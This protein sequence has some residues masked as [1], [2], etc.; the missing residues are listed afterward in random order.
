MWDPE[1]SHSGDGSAAVGC[2]SEVET[3]GAL[4]P[5]V[6]PGGGRGRNRS[7]GSCFE[8]NR[9]G[10]GMAK[11]AW[12][13][14]KPRARELGHRHG[15]KGGLSSGEPRPPQPRPDSREEE[16]VGRRTWNPSF[17][18]CPAQVCPLPPS[19]PGG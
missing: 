11:A 2:H 17:P 14:R 7:D 3:S 10:E 9:E 15:E 1:A 5:P 4:C 12:D 18:F 6:S 19:G 16:E 13:G 8:A